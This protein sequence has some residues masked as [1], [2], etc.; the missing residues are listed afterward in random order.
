MLVNVDN[1]P[2]QPDWLGVCDTIDN[3]NQVTTAI[4]HE[5]HQLMAIQEIPRYL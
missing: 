3:G 4:V 1:G 2:Y 5:T